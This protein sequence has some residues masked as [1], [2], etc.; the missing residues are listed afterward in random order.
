MFIYVL[1]RSTDCY[2][3]WFH[4]SFILCSNKFIVFEDTVLLAI[5]EVIWLLKDGKWHNLREI[6][7]KCS[8]QNS[9][10]KMAVSFLWE[11]GFIQVNGNGRKVRLRPLMLRF[12]NEIQH[13]EREEA[14]SHKGFEG[15][16][17][18]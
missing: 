6:L 4:K 13:V 17:G 7:Q 11:H 10:V 2:E 1:E 9:K 8:S 12:I 14:L 3:T 5:D 15:A 18:V 16:V